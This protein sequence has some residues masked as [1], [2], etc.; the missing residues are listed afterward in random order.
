MNAILGR[1]A[2]IAV[3]ALLIDG[4]R[5]APVQDVMAA[6]VPSLG[7]TLSL[8]DVSKGIIRGGVRA[9]WEMQPVRPGLVSGR[10][11]RG[12]HHAT[13]D[14]EYDAKT[15]SIRH[16]DSS[17]GSAG[18]GQVH[19]VYNTWVQSLDRSIRGELFSLSN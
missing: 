11:V 14:V 6:P 19:R 4:C 15:Y 1:T 7:K 5:S 12:Q 16:R 3:A 8:D 17:W 2:L 13:V 18:S 9:G 10:F